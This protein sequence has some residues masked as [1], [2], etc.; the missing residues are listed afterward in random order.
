MKEDTL[1]QQQS[2]HQ[3][4]V[5]VSLGSRSSWFISRILVL[6]ITSLG[7]KGILQFVYE[8]IFTVRHLSTHHV[9]Q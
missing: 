1:K 2:C 4:C 9:R 8:Q 6:L 5:E 3:Q 7:S